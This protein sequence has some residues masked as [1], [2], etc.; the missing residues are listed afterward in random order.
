VN[1]NT[2]TGSGYAA[3]AGISGTVSGTDKLTLYA[4]TGRGGGG[5]NE[6]SR[7]VGVRYMYLFD[8]F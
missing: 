2:V 1:R 5:T 8:N 3:L 6:T 4:S 7:E